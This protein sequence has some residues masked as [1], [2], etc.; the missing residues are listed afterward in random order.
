V[1]LY[2]MLTG[3]P[4][5]AGENV[6]AIMFQ[7]LNS[8]PVAP[9]TLNSKVPDMLNFIVAKALAKGVD[10][11]YQNAQD[12][13]RDLRACRETLPRSDRP[14]VTVPSSGERKILDGMIITGRSPVADQEEN[15][16]TTLGLSTNFD[17]NEA[18]MR[19][20]ALTNGPEEVD[21]LSKTLKIMRPQ[22]NNVPKARP[23][24]PPRPA[25]VVPT[26]KA[27]DKFKILILFMVALVLAVAIYIK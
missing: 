19:L 14:L 24:V 8:T 22:V 9:S 21:E 4:P 2:E 6:N 15:A 10:D 20:A 12:F 27:A 7:T 13:A 11:R 3:E 23:A 1:M 18:T 16:L 5:F 26:K 25:S 17:S